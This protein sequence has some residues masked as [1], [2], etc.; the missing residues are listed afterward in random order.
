VSR[1][2]W[3]LPLAVLVGV[4]V[5]VPF[6]AEALRTPVDGDSAIIGLMARHP[7]WS[8][9]MWGQPY[10]SPLEAWIA[11]P[12]FALLRPDTATPRLVYFLLGL[13]LI[14]AAYALARALDPRAALPAAMLMACPSPYLPPAGRAAPPAC[15]RRRSCSRRP[16]SGWPAPPSAPGRGHGGAAGLAASAPSP[17]SRC[18]RT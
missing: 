6:W 2:R 8:A 3:E 10:G 15:T 11:A 7:T 17:A 1:R 16:C 9:T 13:G 18:G 12:L 5:R 14:P 4:L